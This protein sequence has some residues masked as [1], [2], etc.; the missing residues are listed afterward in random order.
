MYR[1]IL[2]GDTLPAD[3]YFKRSQGSAESDQASHFLG[4]PS[5]VRCDHGGENTDVALF[6]TMVRG[7]G[8]GSVLTGSSIH[9]QRIERLWR[10]VSSQVTEYFYKL[11]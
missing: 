1:W 6:L 8:R 9:N 10:D 2:Q 3:C 4:L 11:L 7:Q 5:R